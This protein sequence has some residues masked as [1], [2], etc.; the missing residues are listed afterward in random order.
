MG[1]DNTNW[2]CGPAGFMVLM[3]I[4]FLIMIFIAN[5]QGM[6]TSEI[7]RKFMDIIGR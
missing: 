1:G 7:F 3:I 4:A 6:D 2:G 5:K